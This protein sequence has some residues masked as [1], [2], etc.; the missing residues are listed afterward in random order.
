VVAGGW[1]AHWGGK[2]GGGEE[3][4]AGGERDGAGVGGALCCW[5]F[6]E[7]RGEV[8]ETRPRRGAW[9]LG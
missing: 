9:G 5:V 7:G 2:G 6:E 4:G 1:C 3:G 8:G